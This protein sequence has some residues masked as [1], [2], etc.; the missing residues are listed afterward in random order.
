MRNPPPPSP[1]FAARRMLVSA[2]AITIAVSA[3]A[4]VWNLTHSDPAG[5]AAARLSWNAVA[6][7][8]RTSGDVTLV[9][10]E[11]RI[12]AEY[13]GL[14][15]TSAVEV[16]GS[17]LALV[18]ATSITLVDTAAGDDAEPQ[19]VRIPAGSKVTRLATDGDHLLLAAGVAAGGE[20]TVVDGITGWSAQLGELAGLERPRLFTDTIRVDPTGRTIAVAD[21]SSFQTIV[22]RRA[23]DAPDA[24]VTVDNYAAQP[25]AVG[26]QL[27]ATSQVVGRRADLAVHTPGSGVTI[28]VGAAI[29]VGATIADGA[30]VAVTV[31]GEVIRVRP[32]DR[33]PR[34]LATL[35]L[36]G[37]ATPT[38]AYPVLGGTR[39]V[40]V[41]RGHTAVVDTD[42]TLVYSAAGLPALDTEPAWQQRCLAIGAA[43]VDL[44][45]GTVTTE[46]PGRQA[47]T[48]S[49]DGCGVALGTTRRATVA[50]GGAS[51]RLPDGELLAF[52]PDARAAVV[53]GT[54]RT[55]LVV[56]DRDLEADDPVELTVLVPSPA[57][58][59]VFVDR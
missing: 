46:L 7:V 25:L 24:E 45:D 48:Q 9:D 51:A 54:A 47:L 22:V 13:P 38:A 23:G 3:V 56:L 42:G 20:I 11:G 52:A 8:P 21:A 2:V 6:V 39:L 18:G 33:H 4:A 19:R 59:F 57:T 15:R 35:D 44:S 27:V 55:D 50:V 12:V 37:E 26:G 49:A 10:R 16:A 58:E 5:P 31:D 28:P 41:T 36:P 34:R 29:P 53:R 1:N 40:V 43:I 17:H 14:G 32:G 30:L